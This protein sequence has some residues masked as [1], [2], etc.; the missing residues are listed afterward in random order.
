MEKWKN[1]S[2][3][4]VNYIIQLAQLYSITLLIRGVFFVENRY[5]LFSIIS[6]K[7]R[8][9]ELQLQP[10]NEKA[11]EIARHVDFKLTP[12]FPNFWQSTSSKWLPYIHNVRH[13][14]LVVRRVSPSRIIDLSFWTKYVGPHQIK[15]RILKLTIRRS[16]S[17]ISIVFRWVSC[18]ENEYYRIVSAGELNNDCRLNY[19]RSCRMKDSFWFYDTQTENHFLLLKMSF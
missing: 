3:I 9:P 10:P 6:Q 7:C 14:S 2:S 19:E 4:N 1:S 8:V 11:S 5:R 12:F 17:N 13:D 18:S 15:P 16:Q